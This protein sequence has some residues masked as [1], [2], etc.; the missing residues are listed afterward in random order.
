MDPILVTIGSL[1][2]PVW[3]LESRMDF[4]VEL[5]VGKTPV[6]DSSQCPAGLHPATLL[7]A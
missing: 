7:E 3:L 4:E 2:P 5:A 1:F 6:P